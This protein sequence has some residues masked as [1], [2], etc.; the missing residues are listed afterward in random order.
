MDC[1]K[2]NILEFSVYATEIIIKIINVT[3]YFVTSCFTA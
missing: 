3:S 2:Q 1:P